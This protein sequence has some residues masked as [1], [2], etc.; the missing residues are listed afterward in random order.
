MPA[1]IV[2]VGSPIALGG[3][4]EGMDRTPGELRRRGV[5][6]RFAAPRDDGPSEA[7]PATRTFETVR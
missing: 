4:H 2:I 6:A 7:A 3:H 5:V 1:P